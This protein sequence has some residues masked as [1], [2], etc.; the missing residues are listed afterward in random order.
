MLD[1]CILIIILHILRR[2]FKMLYPSQNITHD[3]GI[4]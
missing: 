3:L 2:S 1:R 4:V